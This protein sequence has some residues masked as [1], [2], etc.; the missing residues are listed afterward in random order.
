MGWSR[1]FAAPRRVLAGAVAVLALAIGTGAGAPPASAGG[2]GSCPWTPLTLVNGWHSEQSAFGSGDP[3][4]CIEIDGMVHL[5][6]SL[7]GGSTIKF[8]ALP[9][10]ARPAHRVELNMYTVNGTVGTLIINSTGDM[11]ATGTSATQ[12][13]SLA[14]LSFPSPL[15]PQTGIMPLL[16][17]WQSAQVM[18]GTG[19]PA[20]SVVAGIVHLSGGLT[21][22]AGSSFTNS[23][24]AILP[25]ADIPSD[26]CFRPHTVTADGIGSMLIRVPP[27]GPAGEVDANNGVLTS[28][29]GLSYPAGAVAWQKLTLLP[30]TPLNSAEC[31]TFPS[32]FVTNRVVY[33]TGTVHFLSAF[34]GELAVLPAADAPTHTLYM[35]AS[36]GGSTFVTLRIDPSGAMWLFSPPSNSIVRLSGLSFHLLS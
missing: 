26:D 16:N 9:A 29:D 5:S 31:N 27:V 32:Y 24:A 17:G 11:L 25:S 3:S 4:Y 7:A 34:S 6:G 23:Q 18:R 21:N 20:V 15:T 10:A 33:L 22:S 30:T 14:G 28:L 2:P 19:D 8:A 35:L 12:F 1:A 13:T 36:T